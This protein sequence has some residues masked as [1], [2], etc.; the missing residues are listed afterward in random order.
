MDLIRKNCEGKKPQGKNDAPAGLLLE[1]MLKY[2]PLLI[3][4]SPAAAPADFAPLLPVLDEVPLADTS[5]IVG[6]TRLITFQ[7][8]LSTGQHVS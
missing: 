3:V 5:D 1:R 4:T 8:P 2:F 7:L 6:V